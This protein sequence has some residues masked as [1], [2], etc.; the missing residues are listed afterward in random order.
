[1]N[2]YT[3]GYEHRVTVIIATSEQEAY[4]L[5]EQ[6]TGLA[7]RAKLVST[8]PT[9]GGYAVTHNILPF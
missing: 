3:Y 7:S 4:A 1:M 8:V 5:L 9:L 6:L 2:V